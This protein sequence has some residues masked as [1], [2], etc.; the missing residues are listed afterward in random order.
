V[1]PP[2]PRVYTDVSVF[3]VDYNLDYEKAVMAYHLELLEDTKKLLKEKHPQLTVSTQV[4]KGYIP[5]K[6]LEASEAP[7]VDLIVVGCRG[8]GRLKGWFLGSVSN[9]VVNHCTKPIL[10]VKHESGGEKANE[11]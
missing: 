1:V 4:K 8:L 7:D 10:V 11:V 2:P 6:I 5:D 9:Y 3:T